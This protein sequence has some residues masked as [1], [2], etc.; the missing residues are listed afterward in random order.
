VE[1]VSPNGQGA[2]AGIQ[3]NAVLMQIDGRDIPSALAFE[4]M[5]FKAQEQGKTELII[6]LREPDGRENM[7]VLAIPLG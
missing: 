2:L 1:S 3:A 5:V 4:N 6:L 7:V